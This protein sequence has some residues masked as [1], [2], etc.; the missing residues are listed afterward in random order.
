M[1]LLDTLLERLR[2]K[3]DYAETFGTPHGRRVLA[4]ILRRSGVTFPR[5]EADQEKARLMEGHRHLA[6]SIYRMVHS[7]DEPLLK[8]I[9]EEQRRNTESTYVTDN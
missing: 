3:R 2:L 6:H 4:D 7:S 5:F 9:S 8:L 1:K